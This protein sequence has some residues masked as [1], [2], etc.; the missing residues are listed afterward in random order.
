M[1]R[2]EHKQID[3]FGNKV[4]FVLYQ[5]QTP[6]D[7]WLVFYH[8]AGEVGP[9]DGSQ[10]YRVDQHGYTKHAK[11]GHEFPF[12]IIAPQAQNYFTTINKYFLEWLRVRYGAKK[13][14]ITGLSR[15]GQEVHNLTMADLSYKDQ[16]IVGAVPIAGR[17]DAYSTADPASVKDVPMIAVHGEK[18]TTV[19][20][21]QDK[22]WCERVNAVPGR[23]NAINFISL[24]NVGHDAWSWAYQLDP[25]N[26]VYIFIHSMLQKDPQPVDLNQFKQLAK[27]AIDQIK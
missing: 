5:P 15:G 1:T 26:P 4:N 19:P 22:S 27:D 17:P 23:K 16:L 6:S 10:L 25:T 11:N 8:G 12:N 13:I 9:V 2:T 20:Y 3:V 21:S 14:L 7:C 18:D 24:A